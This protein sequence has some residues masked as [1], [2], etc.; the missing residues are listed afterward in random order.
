MAQSEMEKVDL[1]GLSSEAR[2]LDRIAAEASDSA[3]QA[4]W[5][6]GLSVTVLDGNDI[7]RIAPDGTKTVVKK[8]EPLC[9]SGSE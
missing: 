8:L 9:L 2:D 3:V 5:Q 7:V 4:A 6:K 1:D